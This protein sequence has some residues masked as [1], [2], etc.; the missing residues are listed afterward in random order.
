M[1]SLQIIHENTCSI[2]FWVVFVIQL[3]IDTVLRFVFLTHSLSLTCLCCSGHTGLTMRISLSRLRYTAA[4]QCCWNVN[5]LCCFVCQQRLN[6]SRN[7]HKLIRVSRSLWV[8]ATVTCMRHIVYVFVRMY[9]YLK[10][11]KHLDAMRREHDQVK[12]LE[13][14][15][16]FVIF[17]SDWWGV[18]FLCNS[19]ILWNV[20]IFQKIF[21]MA[22]NQIYYHQ[23]SVPIKWNQKQDLF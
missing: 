7:E 5:L 6:Q 4:S 11:K 3:S 1:C 18:F 20:F 8:A 13:R 22:W 15:Q 23:Y 17:I 14:Q 9:F 21:R 2:F 16:N 10:Q 12:N 19:T